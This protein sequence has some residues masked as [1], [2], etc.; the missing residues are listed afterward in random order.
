MLLKDVF[1]EKE[2]MNEVEGQLY[3]HFK[4]ADDVDMVDWVDDQIGF[5]VKINGKW[6]SGVVRVSYHT[7]LEVLMDFY[8]EGDYKYQ[9]DICW[10][11]MVPADIEV[12]DL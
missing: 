4:H 8:D 3:Q 1:T 7:D 10:C 11:D 5:D 6:V 2:L 9:F 12:E